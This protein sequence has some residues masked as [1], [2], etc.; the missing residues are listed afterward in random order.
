MTLQYLREKQRVLNAEVE[1]LSTPKKYDDDDDDDDEVLTY[2]RQRAIEM[3]FDAQNNS[4][5]N[6]SNVEEKNGDENSE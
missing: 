4:D 5:A 1:K 2:D 6:A 3:S